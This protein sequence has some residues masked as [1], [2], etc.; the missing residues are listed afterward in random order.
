M[1]LAANPSRTDIEVLYEDQ[2]F[3]V[4]NKPAG[5]LV[6]PTP[7]KE[8]F[9]LVSIVNRQY[10]GRLDG[11]HL[12]PCHRLDRDTSGV[13]I[14][15]KGQEYQQ[16]MMNLFKQAAVHKNYLALAH[17]KIKYKAGELK[18]F[19]ADLDE[20][21]Y[22]KN[23]KGR[24]AIT[25]YKV[26]QVKRRYSIVDVT[27]ITGRTNQIRIQFADM[28]HPL[29]G[30]RKYAFARDFSLKFKRAALHAQSIEWR[31]PVMRKMIKVASPIPKDME[32]FMSREA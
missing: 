9:T 19:I 17:G 16:L 8:K 21:K 1:N 28:G 23:T 25:R 3:V 31:H 22:N 24:L 13:I 4:F 26:I 30:D 6:V 14:F 15:A 11:G 27:P 18:S 2:Q 7:L 5:L 29:V 20:Q 10:A 32:E 12:F